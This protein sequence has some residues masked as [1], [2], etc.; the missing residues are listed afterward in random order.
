[1][2]R[3]DDHWVHKK[4][5]TSDYK[6]VIRTIFSKKKATKGMVSADTSGTTVAQYRSDALHRTRRPPNGGLCE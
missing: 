6:S 3:T 1:M 4:N 5:V 2:V